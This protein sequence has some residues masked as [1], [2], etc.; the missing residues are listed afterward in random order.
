MLRTDDLVRIQGLEVATD[1]L[2]TLRFRDGVVTSWA[3]RYG[4]DID[5]QDLAVTPFANWLR[6]TYPAVPNPKVQGGAPWWTPRG[7]IVDQLQ[8][9]VAEYAAS[10]GVSLEG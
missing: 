8:G 5:Y 10:L 1:G 7:D 2:I 3:E 9:L 6:D 4:L